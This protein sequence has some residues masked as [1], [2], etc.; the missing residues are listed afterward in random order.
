MRLI[1]EGQIITEEVEQGQDGR[2]KQ[3]K[4]ADWQQNKT[5][6]EG[7][8]VALMSD[9]DLMNESH[10]DPLML[11]SHQVIL[12]SWMLMMDWQLFKCSLNCFQ[13]AGCCSTEVWLLHSANL[14]P[15]ICGSLILPQTCL[16]QQHTNRIGDVNSQ[17]HGC[18]LFYPSGGGSVR[19]GH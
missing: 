19:Q 12:I 4:T 3:G 9:K 5:T 8:N 15:N 1:G 14:F 7:S 2:V 10:S 17:G 13:T 16:I 6:T 18:Q 11:V